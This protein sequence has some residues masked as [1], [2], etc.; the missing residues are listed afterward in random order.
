MLTNLLVVEGNR[1][2]TEYADADFFN[3]MCNLEFAPMK[4]I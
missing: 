4:T 1:K 2:R 3:R